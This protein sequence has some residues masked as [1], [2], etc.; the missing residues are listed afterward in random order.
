MKDLTEKKRE[1]PTANLLN[2]SLSTLAEIDKLLAATA[3]ERI[4]NRAVMD[5]L[6][7]PTQFCSK[8]ATFPNYDDCLHQTENDR[9][10]KIQ[11]SREIH[12]EW[13]RQT[14]ITLSFQVKSLLNPCVC[15][16]RGMINDKPLCKDCDS[17]AAEDNAF[18]DYNEMRGR[19]QDRLETEEFPQGTGLHS[20]YIFSV[21]NMKGM[22]EAVYARIFHTD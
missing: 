10:K 6:D 21:R 2:S 9:K 5:M 22:H 18:H 13:Q 4:S 20:G 12:A 15:C 19:W 17:A 7:N 14:D 8:N 11:W 3:R 1:A 16:H